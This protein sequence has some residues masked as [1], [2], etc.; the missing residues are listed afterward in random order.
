[1]F[2][3][4]RFEEVVDQQGLSAVVSELHSHGDDMASILG[5]GNC[6]KGLLVAI[7]PK[8]RDTLKTKKKKNLKT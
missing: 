5:K 3:F 4:F 7:V 6:S 2:E 1:M 8:G